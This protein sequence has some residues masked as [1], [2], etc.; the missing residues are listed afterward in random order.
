MCLSYTSFLHGILVR[1]W[2]VFNFHSD[3]G[4][5]FHSKPIDATD[6]QSC[7]HLSMTTLYVHKSI[8]IPLVQSMHL[9]IQNYMLSVMLLESK[10]PITK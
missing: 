3:T 4:C 8:F 6:E 2:I 9:A 10:Q 7:I 5:Y 1:I